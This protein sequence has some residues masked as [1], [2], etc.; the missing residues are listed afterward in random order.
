M[1]QKQIR[2][3]N[4][5]FIFV[6]SLI[7]TLTNNITI[8]AATTYNS[9]DVVIS[10][11][12]DYIIQNGVSSIRVAPGVVANIR[13]DNVTI[14]KSSGRG[15][16]YSDGCAFVIE[17]GSIVTLVIDGDNVIKSGCSSA[18]RIDSSKS[19]YKLGYAGIQVNRGSELTIMGTGN[20]EVTGGTGSGAKGGA[21]IG[22]GYCNDLTGE[23]NMIAGLTPGAI[24][25]NGG[26]LTLYGGN[27]G[28]GIGGGWNGAAS[29]SQIVINDGV[30]NAYGGDY[31][32]GIG[33]GDSYISHPSDYMCCLDEYYIIIN[34]GT[35]KAYGGCHATGIG[36]SDECAIESNSG[37]DCKLNIQLMGGDIYAEGGPPTSSSGIGGSGIGAGDETRMSFNSITIGPGAFI[38]AIGY[39]SYAIHHDYAT[40]DISPVVSLDT[41]VISVLM[42][43]ESDTT[44]DRTLIVKD[45]SGNVVYTYTVPSGFQS[46]FLSLEDKVGTYYVEF[47][48]RDYKIDIDG[49]ISIVSGELS[50]EV[51]DGNLSKWKP[52]NYS[53]SFEDVVIY[54]KSE[55]LKTAYVYNKNQTGYRLYVKAGIT[56]IDMTAH[57]KLW[58][59]ILYDQVEVQISH[60]SYEDTVE[61]GNENVEY[62]LS[63]VPI[64][65]ENKTS[66]LVVFTKTDRHRLN[67]YVD[68]DVSNSQV[69]TYLFIPQKEYELDL[70]DL[71][72][73]YDGVVV[74]PSLNTVDYSL[75]PYQDT[76]DIEY[77]FYLLDENGDRV[78][79]LKSAPVNA[80]KYEVYAVLDKES[81]V[82]IG[83]KVFEIEKRGINIKEISND[84]KEY[85]GNTDLS[86][87]QIDLGIVRWENI[88]N[89][90]EIEF[91]FDYDN[92]YFEVPDIGIS[93]I[94]LVDV[95]LV[96]ND[97]NKNYKMVY[98]NTNENVVSGEIFALRRLLFTSED[99]IIGGLDEIAS[100][101]K[102]RRDTSLILREGCNQHNFN[103]YARTRNYGDEEDVYRIDIIYDDLS[104]NYSEGEWNPMTHEYLNKYSWQPIYED[105]NKIQI[106]NR[107]NRKVNVKTT[108]SLQFLYQTSDM[109][110]T[111]TLDDDGVDLDWKEDDESVYTSDFY[112]NLSGDPSGYNLTEIS[113][114]GFLN[115]LFEAI[116]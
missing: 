21:A 111:T 94:H 96:D 83:T 18:I 3:H 101:D 58:N 36:S 41:G 63:N 51:E 32:A 71:T 99:E 27:G 110:I 46:V 39:K 24:T 105:A 38:R 6:I 104:F 15:N 50:T 95:Q 42:R 5:I 84:F 35:I 62:D 91:T 57:W 49:S 109:K 19:T 28:A 79:E 67:E 33:D 73:V 26:N 17:S 59:D 107:S 90:D 112:V 65:D 9:G 43:F 88:V 47:S 64:D 11:S 72:K 14:D 70:T 56:S 81:Y 37:L 69:F 82:A 22:G 44:Q 87:S 78:E 98:V 10:T 85:D 2:I 115:I 89:R 45:S 7:L 61:Y 93:P 34:G 76:L 29:E 92:S 100:W 53:I 68:W 12:G 75:I 30:I 8:F 108:T 40:E 16:N 31:S 80:G 13:L 20:L 23:E 74:K 25:V 66:T 114:L 116:N 60:P 52:D 48:G 54:D 1:K 86:A 106:V 103:V 77:T 113:H 97:I 55:K 4:L 102:W